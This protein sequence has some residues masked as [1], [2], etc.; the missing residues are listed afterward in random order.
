MTD[1]LTH[2]LL[3]VGGG[4]AG[5]RAAIAAVEVADTASACRRADGRVAGV[6]ID[7]TFMR[8]YSTR[9]DRPR[10]SSQMPIVVLALLLLAD[11]D[12]RRLLFGKILPCNRT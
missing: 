1:V 12:D 9:R 5:L 7:A 2:D 11:R 10:H 6:S 4:A 3:I 8:A